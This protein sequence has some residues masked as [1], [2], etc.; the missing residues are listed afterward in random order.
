MC[1][2]SWPFFQW[3]SCCVFRRL[4]D[5]E[6]TSPLGAPYSCARDTQLG[7]FP[8]RHARMSPGPVMRLPPKRVV[9]NTFSSH[10]APSSPL[11]P[12]PNL[13]DFSR[14]SKCKSMT[15]GGS[16]S[17][18]LYSRHRLAD[19]RCSWRNL[20]ISQGQRASRLGA[21][22]GGRMGTSL[23]PSTPQASFP[24]SPPKFR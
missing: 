7:T 8:Q 12:R 11:R 9:T 1:H 18:A 13:A 6:A 17:L 21:R 5:A 23:G 19:C 22:R 2:P 24:F 16:I 20:G 14:R 10:L 3:C 15:T 4:S